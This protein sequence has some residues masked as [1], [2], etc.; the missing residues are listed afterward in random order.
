MVHFLWQRL[1]PA[2][3]KK[4]LRQL[5]ATSSESGLSPTLR[6]AANVVFVAASAYYRDNRGTGAKQVDPS[7]FFKRT[8]HHT[9]F[10]RFWDQRN[11]KY[12]GRFGKAF[13]MFERELEQLANR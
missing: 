8:G 11:N 6:R 1:S 10:E 13:S 5:F 4:A 7:G 9:E 2:L 3:G 12:R